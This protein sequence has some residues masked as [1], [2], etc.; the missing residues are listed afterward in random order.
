MKTA[1]KSI[2]LALAVGTTS[3]HAAA[4]YYTA[5]H[6]DLGIA[7]A[8]SGE[9]ELHY[10]IHESSVVD[11]VALG[12]DTEFE[13]G[14][15][16][17]SVANPSLPRPSDASYGFMGV[18]AGAPVWTLPEVED[19]AR[20]TFGIGS[21]ELDP[22]DFT[23]NLTLSLL[24]VS[25]PG[26]FSLW[27][28]DGFGGAIARLASADGI[29]GADSLGLTP[30][31]HSHFNWSFTQPGIYEIMFQVDGIHAIDGAATGTATYTFEVAPEPSRA[32]FA[33]LG[34]AALIL[35]RRRRTATV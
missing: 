13:P 4:L 34:L 8:G 14:E 3:S 5:G 2:L 30:G 17:V 26:A 16:V 20:P 18:I 24:S 35:R 23:G 15:L 1:F 7:Y 6:G 25:G 11:G 21:E 29:T 10:H 28:D 32:V 22:L 9:F 19:P 27:E 31:G 12:A 33:G